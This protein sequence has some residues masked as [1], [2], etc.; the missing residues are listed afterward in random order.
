MYSPTHLTFTTPTA[1]DSYHPCLMVGETRPR[2]AQGH[3]AGKL[4]SWNLHP[5]CPRPGLPSSQN[6]PSAL[7]TEPLLESGV[8]VME[9]GER[10]SELIGNEEL[11]ASLGLREEEEM[12][13]L[14]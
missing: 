8:K 6:L 10:P 13:A 4:Q 14:L 9:K 12:E 1:D 11:L 2:E 3:K 5:D 7:G